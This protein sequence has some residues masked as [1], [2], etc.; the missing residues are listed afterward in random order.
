MESAGNLA[1]D[2][3]IYFTRRKLTVLGTVLLNEVNLGIRST[4]VYAR[5]RACVCL[6]VCVRVSVFE[7]VCVCVVYQ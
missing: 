6:N 3:V 5:E 1:D 4:G 7:C 2:N